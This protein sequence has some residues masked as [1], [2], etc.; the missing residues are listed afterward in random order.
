MVKIPASIRY[1][2]SLFD[3]TIAQDRKTLERLIELGS[4]KVKVFGNLKHDSEKLP[5]DSNKLK[6][7]RKSIGSKDILL[8]SST[9]KG[10]EEI[11]F[12]AYK[13][14]NYP[15]RDLLL[16]IAP[17]HQKGARK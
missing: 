8:A 7:L 2:L 5:F 9:H 14:L 6:S 10:E 11:I 17:R 4:E 15:E 3:T 1:L 12:S 13:E 16:V